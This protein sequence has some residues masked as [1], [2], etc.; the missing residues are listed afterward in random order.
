M[1]LTQGLILQ[2]GSTQNSSLPL[3]PVCTR[4]VNKIWFL[5]ARC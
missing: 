3:S 5:L 4:M 2:P 1:P